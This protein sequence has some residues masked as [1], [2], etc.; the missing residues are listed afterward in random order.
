MATAGFRAGAGMEIDVNKR[1]LVKKTGGVSIRRILTLCLAMGGTVFSTAGCTELPEE[2][3]PL[4]VIDGE[5]TESVYTLTEVVIEDVVKTVDLAFDYRLTLSETIFFPVSGRAVQEVYVQKGD[6]VKKGQLLAVLEGGGH[7]SEIRDLEY[8]NARYKLQLGYCDINEA[9]ERSGRWWQYVYRSSHTE[10]EWE[11][12]QSDLTQMEQKYTYQREDYQDKIDMNNMRLE[13]YRKEMETGRI[14]AGMDGV[15]SEVAS[16]LSE[17]ISN[18]KTKAFSIVDDSGGRFQSSETEY[19]D[20]FSE[21]EVYDIVIKSSRNQAVY[22]VT[23]WKM[24]SWGDGAIFLEMADGKPAQDLQAGSRG[25]LTIELGRRENVLAVPTV[26]IHTA[27]GKSYVYVSGEND[28]REIKWV[29]TGLVGDKTTEII[30][31]LEEGE[32]IILK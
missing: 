31:G 30:S 15:V 20:Y 11:R 29:E 32:A 19:A 13:A 8:Q 16:N 9:Y 6:R 22:Q 1:K 14:Y 10:S 4:V 7:E 26:A 12:L 18:V 2:K 3:S 5:N 24:E 23:P 25:Y 28:I 27:D 17:M 21:G